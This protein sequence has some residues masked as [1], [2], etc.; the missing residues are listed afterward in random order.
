MRGTDKDSNVSA[1]SRAV[2]RRGRSGVPVLPA[3][4][5]L[6]RWAQGPETTNRLAARVPRG[7]TVPLRHPEGPTDRAGCSVAE[8]AC[9]C[10]TGDLSRSHVN[11]FHRA[12]LASPERDPQNRRQRSVQRR[13]TGAERCRGRN[14]ERN[15]GG[16]VGP[17]ASGVSFPR[18]RS[19]PRRRSRVAYPPP[20]RRRRKEAPRTSSPLS[21]SLREKD[22]DP[23]PLEPAREGNVDLRGSVGARGVYF[24]PWPWSERWAP[25]LDAKDPSSGARDPMALGNAAENDP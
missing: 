7:V 22:G 15:A 11:L 5:L 20:T 8:T 19:Q 4:V 25:I 18:L 14:A 24:P 21:M 6:R 12:A 16:L 10:I 2:R 1:S 23:S 9:R 13:T 17:W 3:I